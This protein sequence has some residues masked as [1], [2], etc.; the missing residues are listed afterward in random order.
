MALDPSVVERCLLDGDRFTQ[1]WRDGLDSLPAAERR[2]ALCSEIGLIAE[3]AATLVLQDLGLDVFAELAASGAHGVDLL[4]LTPAPQV[5]ALEVKGTVRLGARP[6]L[7]R[8]RLR[9]MSVEWLS[10][11]AN[12]LM[13][14]WELAGL[15]VYGGLAHLNFASMSWRLLLTHDHEHW[16]P[17]TDPVQLQDLRRLECG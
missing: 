6:R 1:A 5:L 9:Q 10:D 2:G 8:S 12:P 7:G 14:E 11:P 13:Q 17:M 15:D 4:L 3:S 16:L